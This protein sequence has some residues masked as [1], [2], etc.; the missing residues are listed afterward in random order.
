VGI[1]YVIAHELAHLVHAHHRPAFFGVL[2]RVMPEWRG[3]KERL[4]GVMA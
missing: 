1:E 2:D 4:E 3:W